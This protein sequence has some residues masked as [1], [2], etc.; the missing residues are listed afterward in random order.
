MIRKFLVVGLVIA[1]AAT[2][3]AQSDPI[4]ERK[5][6]M[7]TQGDLW[8]GDI[9]K[10]VKGEIP[11][12]Q[13]KVTL[14]LNALAD[15]SKKFATLFPETSKSGGSTRALPAIWEKKDDFNARITKL[16]ADATAAMA[17]IKDLDSLK[18][19]QPGL[20]ANCNQCHA[21]YRARG[22]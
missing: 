1:G 7:K 10:M 4:A 19:A 2:A 15:T 11:Y 6:L 13:A 12:E 3:A 20:N 16:G 21:A 9:N 14:T 17:S 22:N 8:Y 5:Q 18:A